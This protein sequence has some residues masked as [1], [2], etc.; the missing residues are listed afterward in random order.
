MA[1]FLYDGLVSGSA[2][3]SAIGTVS[4]SAIV[5]IP[6]ANGMRVVIVAGDHV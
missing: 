1:K 4:G 3:A 6:Y 2:I 5:V